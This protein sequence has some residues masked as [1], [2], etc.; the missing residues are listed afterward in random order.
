MRRRHMLL[1]IVLTLGLLALPGA[2]SASGGHGDGGHGDHSDRCHH[3]DCTTISAAE[4]L[5][6]AAQSNRFEIASGQLAQQRGTSATVRD[7]GTLIATEHTPV[8]QQIEDLAVTLGV[9]LPEGL[10]PRYQALLDRLGT[11][12]GEKFDRVWLKVQWKVH[13]EALHLLLRAAICGEVAEVR[14]LAQ[15]VLPA[16][17]RHLAEVRIALG[18]LPDGHNGHGHNGHG[19]NGHGDDDHHGHDDDD[20]G[21]HRGHTQGKGHFKHGHGHGHGHGH[22]HHQHA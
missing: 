2:A 11:L 19:H 20:H 15:A 5:T 18:A 9:T 16:I 22:K 13:T 21:K 17:T 3:A 6:L 12:S 7:L 8:L 1:A 4:F 10:G 14:A